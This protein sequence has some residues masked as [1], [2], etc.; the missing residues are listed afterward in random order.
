M[1]TIVALEEK[2]LAIFSTDRVLWSLFSHVALRNM[3]CYRDEA[4]GCGLASD[5]ALSR[6]R[7]TTLSRDK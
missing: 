3:A 1:V 2:Y 7:Q 5:V 6:L 4:G